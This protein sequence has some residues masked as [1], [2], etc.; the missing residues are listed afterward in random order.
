MGEAE[1]KKKSVDVEHSLHKVRFQK[2]NLTMAKHGQQN[3]NEPKLGGLC[4]KSFIGRDGDVQS[5]TNFS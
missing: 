2:K 4:Y 5:W 3:D 1:D